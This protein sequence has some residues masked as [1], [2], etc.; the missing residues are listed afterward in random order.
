MGQT[1]NRSFLQHIAYISRDGTSERAGPGQIFDRTQDTADPRAFNARAHQD[2]RQFRLMVMPYDGGEIDELKQFTRTLMRQV[3]RDLRREVD[4]VAAVHHNTANPHIHIAVRGGRPPDDEL[5]I[6]R[7]YLMHGVRHRA[8]EAV[9][10]VLGPRSERELAAF[11]APTINADRSTYIDRDLA[12]ASRDG[13]VDISQP[14]PVPARSDWSMKCLRLHHLKSRGLAKH[15]KGSAWRLKDGWRETLKEM[16][17][18]QDIQLAIP[19]DMGERFDPANLKAFSTGIPGAVVTGRLSAVVVERMR[20][21]R[22]VVVVE[23]LDGRQWTAGMPAREARALPETGSIVTMTAPQVVSHPRRPPDI[24]SDRSSSPDDLPPRFVVHSW[25][26]VDQ[27]IQRH[28]YTWLD[29]VDDA[30]VGASGFGAEVRAARLARQRWLQ[31][32]G[33]WPAR[34]EDLEA[35]EMRATASAEAARL[36]KRFVTLA[37]REVFRG[38]YEGHVDTAQGRFAVIVTPSRF[39]LATWTEGQMPVLGQ[40]ASV[41]RSRVAFDRTLTRGLMRPD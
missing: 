27:M 31:A 8:E 5:F 16:S 11:R 15:I 29:G 9:T 34:P 22:H 20:T 24:P 39:V 7:R 32:E 26:P 10:S 30:L 40:P 25:I 17:R 3:E 6:A 21:G 36:G 19:I 12:W 14:G 28:A 1:G 41:E 2:V 4:W 38:T 23:G 13:R 37:E 35:A 18:Q 33:L